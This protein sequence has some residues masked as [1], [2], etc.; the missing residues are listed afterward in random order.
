MITVAVVD[1]KRDIREGLRIVL[2]TTE[3][4]KCL[5]VFGSGRKAIE[6]ITKLRPDVVIMDVEMPDMSGIECVRELKKRLPELGVIMFSVHADQESVLQ[7]LKAGAY[8]YLTKNTFPSKVLSAIREVIEGGAPMSA[9][10]AR[11]VVMSFHNAPNEAFDLSRR[12]REVLNLLCKGK[13]YRNIAE[14]LYISTNTVRFHLKNIYKKLE[15]GSKYEAVI[16]ASKE[17]IV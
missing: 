11:K 6:G 15:V 12:E 8:G 7:S 16:K 2:D 17:G 10:V 3:G 1:D 9:S 5:N 14:N 13:N 4:F